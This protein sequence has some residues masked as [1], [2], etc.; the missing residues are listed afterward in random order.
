MLGNTS[1]ATMVN[2]GQ[3]FSYILKSFNKV[4]R[5][6]NICSI[7]SCFEVKMTNIQLL[8]RL[9]AA[10]LDTEIQFLILGPHWYFL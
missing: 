7:Q 2:F 10:I 4:V 9:T 6:I 1:C 5:C 8:L 3:I